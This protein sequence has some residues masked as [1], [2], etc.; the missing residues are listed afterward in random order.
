V[1]PSLFRSVPDSLLLE[2]FLQ[3]D[4]EAAFDLLTWRYGAM[5]YRVCQRILRHSQDAEDAFQATFLTLARKAATIGKRESIR[6]GVSSF[7]Q[8]R[9]N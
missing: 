4:D 7:F 3:K 5:V 1:Q 8:T 6:I 2:R 9:M